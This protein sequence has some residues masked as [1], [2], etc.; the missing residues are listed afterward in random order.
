M[1]YK[2]LITSYQTPDLDGT[3]CMIAYAEYLVK[4]GEE[5][6]PV[7][8]GE[9]QRE[10]QF[11]LQSFSI[12]VPI[13]GEEI[14]TSHQHI[15]L[16][17]ASDTV[18]ISKKIA[19]EQVTEIIDHREINEA[20]A[21]INA[22][23]QIELVGSAAT[24]I[25]EKFYTQETPISKEAAI[26]LYSAIISNTVNFHAT[27]TTD[28]DKKMADWLLKHCEIP[29]TYIHDMFAFKSQ[30]VKPVKEMFKDTLAV[31]TINE[32][33]VIS[34]QVEIL[35][36]EGFIQKNMP[37]IRTSLA[38][39]KSEYQGDFVYL[40]CIDV[41]KAE[42]IFVVLDDET[43]K[44]FEQSLNVLFTENVGR[45]QGVLMRKTITPILKKYLEQKGT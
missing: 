1:E 40:T 31:F 39:L 4:S 45:K 29:D 23:I 32:K 25:A 20:S 21:F 27:V 24:L 5:V 43:K 13:S 12:P 16:V 11:V 37:E 33:K 14:L 19:P 42:N 26:L 44:V 36:G 15:K 2:T 18:G 9:P 6:Q 7:V 35:D 3:A 30:I 17:D 8:F 34:V 28:R 38:A 10:A 22:K 41:E